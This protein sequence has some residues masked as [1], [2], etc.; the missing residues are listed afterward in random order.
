[1]SIASHT[2]VSQAFHRC[3]AGVFTG[4]S[5]V[6]IWAQEPLTETL[7][8]DHSPRPF[9]ETL[10]RD[11]SPRPFTETLHR[12]P[13]PRPFTETI[14]RVS[15]SN[16]TFHINPCY[17][18]VTYQYPTHFP[19][20]ILSRILTQNPHTNPSLNLGS[21]PLFKPRVKGAS[22]LG[23][24]GALPPPAPLATKPFTNPCNKTFHTTMQ[25]TLHTTLQQ[26][27]HTTFHKDPFTQTLSHNHA[28]NPCNKDPFTQP[29]TQ[30]FT[31]DLAQRP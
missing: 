28:T 12:D 18:P 27:F 17:T 29:F 21:D 6:F 8:R 19:F 22:R 4:V 14:H 26:T 2:G 31:K 20:S 16:Q 11:P 23:F 15:R 5:R 1:M 30:P 7:H 24:A 25:Q 10:H 13:S 9:T 3:F